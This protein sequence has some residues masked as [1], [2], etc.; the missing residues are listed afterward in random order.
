MGMQIASTMT[1][2]S[3]SSSGN[4]TWSPLALAGAPTPQPADKKIY[5]EKVLLQYYTDGAVPVLVPGGLCAPMQRRIDS[6][7]FGIQ[8]IKWN[9][10]PIALIGDYVIC[11]STSQSRALTGPGIGATIHIGTRR[12]S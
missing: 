10:K 6:T 1:V 8:K 5:V 12:A 11:G 9:D 2:D 7:K 4:C 3:V